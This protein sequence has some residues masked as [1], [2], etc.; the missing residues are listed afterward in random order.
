MRLLMN[1]FIKTI[2][3]EGRIFFAFFWKQL[4]PKKPFNIR[5]NHSFLFLS[6]AITGNNANGIIRYPDWLVVLGLTAL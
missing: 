6:L 3:F 2:R 1:N 5:K 4:L